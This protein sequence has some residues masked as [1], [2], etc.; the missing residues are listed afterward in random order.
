MGRP[1][2]KA[3]VFSRAEGEIVAHNIAAAWT[4][5]GRPKRFEGEGA[6]FIETGA[7][8]AGMGQGHFY[9]EPVPE[10][11]LRPPSVVWHGAKVLYE[12]YWL[13]TKF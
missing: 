2:P 4:G 12:K 3:G 8:R 1:L 9:A 13:F 5:R 6:C 10:V 7:G 11:R